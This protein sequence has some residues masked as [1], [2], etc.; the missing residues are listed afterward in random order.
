[1]ITIVE[2]IIAIIMLFICVVYHYFIKQIEELENRILILEQRIEENKQLIKLE[3]KG[4]L[5]NIDLR[6]KGKMK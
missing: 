1:M 5:N 3:I 2:I 6:M 4:V